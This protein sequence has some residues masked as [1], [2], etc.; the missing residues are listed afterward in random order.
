MEHISV[1]AVLIRKAMLSQRASSHIK[2]TF[3]AENTRPTMQANLE[4]E[5]AEADGREQLE[6]LGKRILSQQ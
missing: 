2:L 6:E 5:K 1:V 3:Q 4:F